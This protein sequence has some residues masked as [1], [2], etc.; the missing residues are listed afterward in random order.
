VVV[1][2]A[3]PL[4]DKTTTNAPPANVENTNS[5]TFSVGD[6]M[7]LP[8]IIDQW[9]GPSNAVSAF[10]WQSLSKQDQTVLTNYQPSA[11]SSN[12]AQAVV[13]QALNKIIW[14]PSI[15][16]S[17]RFQGISLRPETTDLMKEGPTGPSTARL[18]RLLLEDAYPLE[19]SKSTN[20][21]PAQQ[22]FIVAGLMMRVPPRPPTNAPATNMPPSQ[23]VDIQPGLP[24]AGIVFGL[25]VRPPT[26]PPLTI[27]PP[28]N[29]KL[30]EPARTNPPSTNI[31]SPPIRGL[32]PNVPV[33]VAG[34]MATPP[35]NPPSTNV[36]S[37]PIRGFFIAGLIG[38]PFT[39]PPPTNPPH[40]IAPGELT[41]TDPPSAKQPPAT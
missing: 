8:A 24:V 39:N 41:R 14:G 5:S 13:V 31:I 11:L 21:P 29:A 2:G 23:P 20:P 12:Q 35:T 17:N 4:P 37:P 27:P 15:Y 16:E 18:N 9:R 28:T 38:R 34:A 22:L 19:L 40:T 1:A 3:V 26:N 32:Q 33:A 30:A 36:I 10:L 25:M 7:D 6:I